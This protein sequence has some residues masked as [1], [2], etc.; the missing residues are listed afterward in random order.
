MSGLRE[1]MRAVYVGL[2]KDRERCAQSNE[3]GS[4]DKAVAYQSAAA[5]ILVALDENPPTTAQYLHAP[6]DDLAGGGCVR[7]DLGG[8]FR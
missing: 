7:E 8:L 3:P 6:H 5:R 1:A 2:L 4:A